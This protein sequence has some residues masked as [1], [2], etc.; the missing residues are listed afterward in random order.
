MDHQGIPPGWCCPPA[1]FADGNN[2]YMYPG[3]YSAAPSNPAYLPPAH[4]Y[5]Y[6]VPAA[7]PT[8]PEPMD[9]YSLPCMLFPAQAPPSL[10]Q[11]RVEAYAQQYDKVLLPPPL[12]HGV[13]KMHPYPPYQPRLP[14]HLHDSGSLGRLTPR[15]PQALSAREP[16]GDYARHPGH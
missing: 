12:S 1:F 2:P 10:R 5:M 4:Y 13:C 16:P 8:S 14:R 15:L 3:G 7:A 11:Q 6:P 9:N